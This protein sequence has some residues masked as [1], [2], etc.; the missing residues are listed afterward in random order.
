PKIRSAAGFQEVTIP[1][2]VLLM[3]ASSEDLTMAAS[4]ASASLCGLMSG[5]I[6][7]PHPTKLAFQ[8]H[9][10]ARAQC[11]WYTGERGQSWR[12]PVCATPTPLSCFPRVDAPQWC[13]EN[14]FYS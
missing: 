8:R 9:N 7:A 12:N 3:I 11:G 13:E 4:H 14:P 6:R 10:P 5:L 1:S 2:R